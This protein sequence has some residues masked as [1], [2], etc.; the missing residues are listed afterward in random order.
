VRSVD[1]ADKLLRAGAD[2][3]AVNTAAIRRPELITEIAS[4]FGAQCMV[5]SIEA[6]RQAKG[7]WECYTDNGRERTGREVVSWVREAV[8]LGAG[9]V[10][11]TS[12][13]SE[14]TRKGYDVELTRAVT[15]AVRV[16]VIASGGMGSYEHIM[17]VVVEGGADGVAMADFLHYGRGTV[18][19]VRSAA[20]AMQLNVRCT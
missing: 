8:E 18:A 6:K 14:G 16:P 2:K 17:E 15:S 20:L 4:R 11:L 5:I 7:R 3:V 1:D 19:D 12:V 9:E 13:D 10:L